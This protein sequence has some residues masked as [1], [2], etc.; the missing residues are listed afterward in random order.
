M[1]LMKDSLWDVVAGNEATPGEHQ[2]DTQRKFMARR[3]CMLSIIMLAIDLL[4]LYLLGDPEDP[5][6]FGK[7]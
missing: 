5:K 4:L 7:N 3:N 1:V 2:A 6:L